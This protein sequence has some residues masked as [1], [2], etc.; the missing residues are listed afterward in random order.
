MTKIQRTRPTV[1]IAT[2]I[3]AFAALSAN[4]A[5]NATKP[6]DTETLER[7]V[8]RMGAAIAVGAQKLLDK[9][10]GSRILF[11][12]D[13][14]ALHEAMLT[15]LRDGLRRILREERIPFGNFAVRD[16]GVE[17]R[18]ADEGNRQRV[19][20][21]LRGSTPGAA[22]RSW[23]SVS[24]RVAQGTSPRPPRT[25]SDGRSPSLSTTR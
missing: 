24:T 20:G 5:P 17:L 23:R 7:D 6:D 3:V 10:G 2:L 13:A 1:L 15:E 18:I 16:D 19:L 14:G 21:R 22:S 12:V 25:I 8:D 4:A 9:Q 11:G